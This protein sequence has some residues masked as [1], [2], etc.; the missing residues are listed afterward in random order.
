MM[1]DKIKA[2]YDSFIRMTE[3]FNTRRLCEVFGKAIMKGDY[4]NKMAEESLVARMID[5]LIYDQ[6]KLFQITV[7]SDTELFRARAVLNVS[8]FCT[9][10]TGVSARYADMNDNGETPFVSTGFD[11]YGSKE[12][13]MGKTPPARNNIS[14]MSYLY[15]AEDPYT[16]CA[17]IRPY[18][19]SVISLAQFKT[20]KEFKLMDFSPADT[21]NL[22]SLMHLGEKLKPD[23]AQQNIS[24]RET[25]KWIMRQFS[26]TVGKP[27]QYRV[28]QY[29]SDYIRKTGFDGIRYSSSLTGGKNITLFNSHEANI[30]FVSSKLVY[31]LS[32]K[33][34]IMDI[35]SGEQ[36]PVV[37]NTDEWNQECLYKIRN[38]IMQAVDQANNRNGNKAE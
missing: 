16:A 9:E 11:K 3:E 21:V 26:Q 24:V 37:D 1:D 25:I 18:L 17:E 19:R 30:Q 6:D 14:G 15:L 13:P 22:S 31:S 38:E 34:Q 10:I 35:N 5:E 29:I 27:E 23:G 8:D 4:T 36:I 7:P 20:K 28:S 32:Q 12:A 2:I 33:Y